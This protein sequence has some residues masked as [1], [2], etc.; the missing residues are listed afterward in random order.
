M[1]HSHAPG[2]RVPRRQQQQTSSS[3]LTAVRANCR[4]SPLSCNA[5]ERRARRRVEIEGGCCFRTT[6]AFAGTGSRKLM[7]RSQC[8]APLFM[9]MLHGASSGVGSSN[10]SD[11]TSDV[12]TKRSRNGHILGLNSESVANFCRGST[13]WVHRNCR[14]LASDSIPVLS[15]GLFDSQDSPCCGEDHVAV[16]LKATKGD[17]EYSLVGF[18]DKDSTPGGA[19]SRMTVD[20]SNLRFADTTVVGNFNLTVTTFYMGY[21]LE[22]Q[23][24]LRILPDG[25]RILPWGSHSTHVQVLP[26]S[27]PWTVHESLPPFRIELQA[28]NSTVSHSDADKLMVGVRLFRP[29]DLLDITQPSLEGTTSQQAHAGVAVF[30][31]LSVKNAVGTGY[32]FAF[33]VIGAERECSA[34]I[35]RRLC[36]EWEQSRNNGGMGGYHVEIM[37]EK[38]IT[39]VPD[40]IVVTPVGQRSPPWKIGEA[41]RAFR[42]TVH[43]SEEISVVRSEVTPLDQFY[44]GVALFDRGGID[45]T[46][47]ALGGTTTRVL[48]AGVADFDDLVIHDVVG[49]SFTLVFSVSWRDRCVRKLKDDACAGECCATVQNLDIFPQKMQIGYPFHWPSFAEGDPLGTIAIEF[50]DFDGNIL[51][52]VGAEYGMHTQAFLSQRGALIHDKLAGTVT[53]VV[54]G[55]I[56]L[57]QDLRIHEHAGRSMSIIFEDRISQITTRSPEFDVFPKTIV[58]DGFL[59]DSVTGGPI[60]T[61]DANADISI[62]LVSSQGNVLSSSTTLDNF[63]VEVFG[64]RQENGTWIDC[65]CLLGPK[66]A[67]AKHGKA[68]FNASLLS[69]PLAVGSFSLQFRLPRLGLSTLTAA[70]NAFT[71]KPQGIFIKNSSLQ[72]EVIVGDILG[73]VKIGFNDEFGRPIESVGDLSTGKFEAS[74]IQGSKTLNLHHLSGTTM[75]QV[76]SGGALFEDLR[77]QQYTGAF[78]SI[79]FVFTNKIGNE[80]TTFVLTSLSFTVRPARLQINNTVPNA[81][82]GLPIPT[83]NVSLQ[84][85]DG[86]SLSADK[87]ER[88]IGISIEL[89]TVVYRG[90]GEPSHFTNFTNVSWETCAQLAIAANATFF[91]TARKSTPGVG[92]CRFGISMLPSLACNYG[93]DEDTGGCNQDASVLAY[94]GVPPASAWKTGDKTPYPDGD[95]PDYYGVGSA[96]GRSVDGSVCLW[97]NNENWIELDLQVVKTVTG[98]VTQGREGYSDDVQYITAYSLEIS[99]DG[100]TYVPISCANVDGN[101]Y[102]VGNSDKST[103]VN[104]TLAQP[105]TARYVKLYVPGNHFIGSRCFRMGVYV[106]KDTVLFNYYEVQNSTSAVMGSKYQLA[107]GNWALFSALRIMGLYGIQSSFIT[108]RN[109]GNLLRDVLVISQVFTIDPVNWTVTGLPR[110]GFILSQQLA[111]SYVTV[112]DQHRNE[113]TSVLANQAYVIEVT[114]LRNGLDMNHRLALPHSRI[115]PTNNLSFA[116]RF[117]ETSGS[118]FRVRISM[119][120][121]G[122]NY[123]LSFLS[124]AF[125]IYPDQLTL[126]GPQGS[127]F[128]SRSDSSFQTLWIRCENSNGTLLTD[129]QPQ[130]DLRVV[131]SL[132][133][134]PKCSDSVTIDCLG[135]S[136]NVPITAGVAVFSNVTYVAGAVASAELRFDIEPL[137]PGGGPFVVSPKFTILP[138][139]L[140]IT[141]GEEKFDG[142]NWI[143]NKGL[144]DYAVSTRGLAGDIIQTASSQGFVVTATLWQAEYTNLSQALA[145]QRIIT[146]SHDVSR[147]ASAIFTDLQVIEATGQLKLRFTLSHPS[148]NITVTNFTNEFKAI[149][150]ALLIFETCFNGKP[151]HVNEAPYGAPFL[152]CAGLD[153]GDSDK[154]RDLGRFGYLTGYYRYEDNQALGPI[155]FNSRGIARIPPIS[156]LATDLYLTTQT[157]IKSSHSF[158]IGFKLLVGDVE[159]THHVLG[160]TLQVISDG[161]AKFDGLMISSIPVCSPNCTVT[162]RFNL[163]GVLCSDT[164]CTNVTFGLK[165]PVIVA[166]HRLGSHPAFPGFSTVHG[167]I[168][169]SCIKPS[170]FQNSQNQELLQ[171]SLVAASSLKFLTRDDITVVDVASHS[172][173]KSVC[174]CSSNSNQPMRPI[175]VPFSIRTRSY[176]A[177]SIVMSSVSEQFREGS[178]AIHDICPNGTSAN[179]TAKVCESCVRPSLVD[180]LTRTDLSHVIHNRIKGP[181]F[182]PPGLPEETCIREERDAANITCAVE[183]GRFAE[184]YLAISVASQASLV[185][186]TLDTCPIET[187]FCNATGSIPSEDELHFVS[188]DSSKAYAPLTSGGVLAVLQTS[189]TTTSLIP[190]GLSDHRFL[191]YFTNSADEM[192]YE[193]DSKLQAAFH[194]RLVAS[195]KHIAFSGNRQSSIMPEYLTA[196]AFAKPSSP[197]L[198]ESFPMSTTFK[199]PPQALTP[200]IDLHR[201]ELWVLGWCNGTHYSIPNAGVG[202]KYV[203]PGSC[204]DIQHEND[205]SVCLGAQAVPCKLKSVEAFCTAGANSYT[206]ADQGLYDGSLVRSV[207]VTSITS[208]FQTRLE[209]Q[210]VQ[211]LGFTNEGQ[212]IQ[213]RNLKVICQ[214][215]DC[216]DLVFVVVSVRQSDNSFVFSDIRQGSLDPNHNYAGTVLALQDTCQASNSI[217]THETMVLPLWTRTFGAQVYYDL[218]GADPTIDSLVLSSSN[219]LAISVAFE[220]SFRAVSAGDNL[221]NSPYLHFD[222]NRVCGNGV[223]N[224][225]EQCD[226]GN[227]E[228]GDLC[229]SECIFEK[230]CDDSI[231]Q[232]VSHSNIGVFYTKD[233]PD[234]TDAGS[235]NFVQVASNDT[236]L[237]GDCS[238]FLIMDN[239]KQALTGGGR[240]YVRPASEGRLADWQCSMTV[241]VEI[242]FVGNYFFNLGKDYGLPEVGRENIYVY[243]VQD[244]VFHANKYKLDE[245]K[246]AMGC[247][248]VGQRAYVAGGYKQN[249]LCDPEDN[250]NC[251]LVMLDDIDVIEISTIVEGA[252]E[253]NYL[254]SWSPGKHKLSAARSFIG[255]AQANEFV[256]F[257][258]GLTLTQTSYAVHLEFDLLDTN[259]GY[260]NSTHTCCDQGVCTECSGP[261]ARYLHAMAGVGPL[262]LCAGGRGYSGN[263]FEVDIYNTT[264]RTF[265]VHPTGLSQ[266][267]YSLAAASTSTKAFFAGG[268]SNQGISSVVEVF[269]LTSGH[270]SVI[271][272][273]KQARYILTGVSV[274][275]HVLFAGGRPA[276]G[277]GAATASDWVDIYDE[278]DDAHSSK[279]MSTPRFYHFGGSARQFAVFGLGLPYDPGLADFSLWIN[280]PQLKNFDVYDM[281]AE[282]LVVK[283]NFTTVE[284]SRSITLPYYHRPTRVNVADITIN[285][286]AVVYG[287][288]GD[289]SIGG[290]WHLICE[291]GFRKSSYDTTRIHAA[292][293]VAYSSFVCTCTNATEFFSKPSLF[294]SDLA[295][296]LRILPPSNI[297]DCSALCSPP[298]TSVAQTYVGLEVV[299]QPRGIVDDLLITPLTNTAFCNSS[300]SAVVSSLSIQQEAGGSF[301]VLATVTESTSDG[302]SRAYA[303][304]RLP[305]NISELDI[306]I[307]MNVADAQ[308]HAAE[309]TWTLRCGKSHRGYV[310]FSFQ[311][312]PTVCSV[313][314]SPFG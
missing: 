96:T 249:P 198:K 212:L 222:V 211:D 40:R 258:G 235:L 284:G 34:G 282:S 256:A 54:D 287:D 17:T 133:S 270:F 185:Y 154:I 314:I 196:K 49:L 194:W 18:T 193:L 81:I 261:R 146:A 33:F 290:R 125:T 119:K 285:Q 36:E 201:G 182:D 16:R 225:G 58:F 132:V 205:T 124:D 129:I 269:D 42:V 84:N 203:E 309:D 276:D 277:Q 294:P 255:S 123:T 90:C 219:S 171:D 2:K 226:D 232:D 204:A 61:D 214:D 304:V 299:L 65:G 144:G 100:S 165:D 53:S 273:L 4:T 11:L 160:T 51:T 281:S 114:L 22:Y 70:S 151:V 176:S 312:V 115:M 131:L 252:L 155:L 41:L 305:Y 248:A 46:D 99:N 186:Y 110:A 289:Y 94:D 228:D 268:I 39:I 233:G 31:G 227:L 108:A 262:I 295:V 29:Q 30:S 166:P 199:F 140:Y 143:I 56:S 91:A 224:G 313:I 300:S 169:L 69:I 159:Y 216:D 215:Q 179:V 83:L 156:I 221:I 37:F 73:A 241:G 280:A 291:P 21:P 67:V 170:E 223:I 104:N 161:V 127:V 220:S 148:S 302:R 192:R 187:L 118:D 260:V 195:G 244:E 245:P 74:L 106:K 301:K 206:I 52:Q 59:R 158:E 298:Q 164:W 162:L 48:D 173:S 50:T 197:L 57:F 207:G 120:M 105:V 266:A 138:N 3:E 217:L 79:M 246:N 184:F 308:A 292:L 275:G 5:A 136:I 68:T 172:G 128:D 1:A 87:D 265:T 44:V 19:G 9:M 175:K 149:P 278:Q 250:T 13:S 27:G 25:L 264:S 72:T 63:T 238:E 257:G 130:D 178:R 145:G 116:L 64:A 279:R 7:R 139:R 117:V 247:A 188:G 113:V 60:Q 254:D 167:E 240:S 296:M 147:N 288:T 307:D 78:V 286:S 237:T 66:R 297:S 190:D 213:P 122:Y 163:N 98:I 236:G 191:G 24:P 76:S 121:R 183:F 311:P 55:G 109:R 137:A 272:P 189:P 168:L 97:S 263:L 75:T 38:P 271:E 85:D 35:L 306:N 112:V 134:K 103:L 253:E 93:C 152:Q 20:F 71:L 102:C 88:A 267:R 80:T 14:M 23:A 6:R 200:E 141:E 218:T 310:R 15:V 32:R 230:R 303:N 243:N 239:F 174:G 45:L 111:Q 251:D 157:R 82:T 142:V 293:P 101:G 259:H 47:F 77:V 274:P 283:G 208:I 153:A 8:L 181:T 177:S 210:S 150:Y 62:H 26:D 12:S 10:S 234:N 86:L 231:W 180:A 135:G 89:H 92:M 229:S 126:I 43:D 28:K 209:V 107:H 95:D 202:N 242:M